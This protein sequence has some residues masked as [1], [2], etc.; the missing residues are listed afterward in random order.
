MLLLLLSNRGLNLW[1]VDRQTIS[2][3]EAQATYPLSAGALT[4]LNAIFVKPTIQTTTDTVGASSVEA[5]AGASVRVLRYGVRFSVLPTTALNF[6][7][8]TDGATWTTRSTIAVADLPA[9]DKLLWTR[10]DPTVE[11]QYFRITSATV[12]TADDFK[13]VTAESEVPMSPMNRDTYANQ[14]NKYET[15]GTVTNYFFEKKIAPQITVWPTPDSDDFY[16]DAFIHRQVQDVGTLM[17]EIEI[18]TRWYDA[19]LT[20]LS[21]RLALELPGVN[22]ERITLLTGL[23]DK[24]TLEV[25]GDETDRAPIYL[26]P[27]IGGYT[28]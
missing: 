23:A 20:H 9:V 26:M 28:S 6:E 1:A 15:S 25:E 2:L 10:I 3:Y 18:P 11:A 19:I 22:P 17:Q 27:N 7:S 13:L 12:F 21:A 14:P 4:L 24:M 5:D 16:I 8:S